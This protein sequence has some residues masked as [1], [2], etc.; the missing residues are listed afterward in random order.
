VLSLRIANFSIPGILAM[1]QSLPIVKRG[2]I[3]SALLPQLGRRR[4]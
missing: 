3:K 2:E 4:G 1:I